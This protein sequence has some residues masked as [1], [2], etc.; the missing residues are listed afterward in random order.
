MVQRKGGGK[1][2]AEGEGE[3]EGDEEGRE[4]R[5]SVLKVI[6]FQY[7]LGITSLFKLPEKRSTHVAFQV[8]FL[9]E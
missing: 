3:G 7:T 8:I 2:E 9:Q 1:A 5:T 6:T 4:T